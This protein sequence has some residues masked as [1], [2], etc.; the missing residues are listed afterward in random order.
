MPQL[1]PHPGDPAAFDLPEHAVQPQ[2]AQ[3]PQSDLQQTKE[4]LPGGD[5]DPAE[6][7]V[8]PRAR[9]SLR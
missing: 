9:D 5:D 1:P 6:D 8:D 2:Q 4:G 7:H 3:E